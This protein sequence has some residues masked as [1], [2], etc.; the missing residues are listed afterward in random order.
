[1]VAVLSRPT[2]RPT[3]FIASQRSAFVEPKVHGAGVFC[4]CS[5]C[6]PS[7]SLAMEAF[8]T[9]GAAFLLVREQI[10]RR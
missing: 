5:G 3:F 10:S 1:M 9:L 4:V 7:I 2:Q 8:Q 6:L